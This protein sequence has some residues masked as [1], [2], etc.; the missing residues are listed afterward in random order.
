VVHARV[1]QVV[2]VEEIRTRSIKSIAGDKNSDPEID[3]LI[4][5]L[6]EVELPF[7]ANDHHEFWVMNKNNQTPL[8]MVFCISSIPRDRA[9]I[10]LDVN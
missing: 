10:L 3:K 6:A 2:I 9:L 4:D 8:A 7:P 5:F 1:R